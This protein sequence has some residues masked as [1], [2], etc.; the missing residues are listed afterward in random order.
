MARKK[1]LAEK[2]HGMRRAAG[3]LL[4]A[5]LLGL[6]SA[7]AAQQAAK[8][9]PHP[10][11][12]SQGNTLY[13]VGYA[14]LDTQWRWS[15]PQVIRE[16]IPN[17]MHNNFRLF[18]Q[19]PDYVFNF[20]GSRRYEFMK[21]Y[22]PDDYAKVKQY[23]KAGNWFP[24]GS[25]VDEGDANVPSAESLVRHTLYGNHFFRR[26]FGVASQEFMLPDC[27]GFPYAL[28]TVLAHCG[29]KG[30]STQKLTWGS[31]VGIPFPVG[32]WQGPDGRGVVAA[33]D[34]GS[35]SAGFREDL[36]QNTSWLARIQK[37][38]AQ[39]G[40]FVDYHYYGTGDRGGAPDETSVG[41]ME[42]SIVGPGQ[43]KVVSSKAD[44]MVKTLT[45]AQV[46]K[47]PRYK[48]EL[49]LTQHSAGSITSEAYMKRWNRK[50]ELL[51]DAAERA[52]VA[53]QWLGGASY[54]SKRLYDAWDL[55]LGSQM[56]DMLPGTSLPVAYDYCWNDEL[57][58]LNQFGAVT[59]DAVGSVASVMNTQARGVALVVYNPLATAREGRGGSHS[60]L[61]GR[62]PVAGAGVWAGRPAHPDPDA[63]A[64]RQRR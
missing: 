16:F 14:H 3:P 27:F 64:R 37:T 54:P 33:L 1:M 11:D 46:A 15:Y 28:P 39:S 61:S 25:S 36:S 9:V 30:F 24:C 43:I 29:I 5:A 38:G 34:P 56:H 44:E 42:K 19:Y 47:L 18:D 8:L 59:Q 4:A 58:A 6:S 26:E 52:S 55:V 40:S 60:D 41:W 51:A 22:Y 50:N 32:V 35:Y 13:L 57:L 31:A 53:A 2:A 21:E 45:P 12:L 7:V 49:L 63:G 10:T 23:V 48:G 20:S 17:T 62:G